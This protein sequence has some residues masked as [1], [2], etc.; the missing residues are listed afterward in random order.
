MVVKCVINS[1]KEL[2]KEYFEIGYTPNSKID[3]VEGRKYNVYGICLWRSKL[4]YLLWDEC[5]ISVWYPCIMFSM[6]DGSIP[7]S[8]QFR[9]INDADVYSVQAIFGYPEL[10]YSESHFAALMELDKNAL[11][12]FSK[13][14]NEIDLEIME[15]M[16]RLE[17]RRRGQPPT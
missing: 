16:E 2:P 1:G 11:E 4:H 7:T 8:W 3:L 5:N 9:Y 14:K 13:R 10:A 17:E 15:S 6:E 12:I